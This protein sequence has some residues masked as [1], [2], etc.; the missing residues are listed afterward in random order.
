MDPGRQPDVVR[1]LP[2]GGRLLVY[3]HGLL[4]LREA[5]WILEVLEKAWRHGAPLIVE[6]HFYPD[7]ASAASGLALLAARVGA[8]VEAVYEAAMHEAWDGV[9]RLH[10]VVSEL[11]SMPRPD[12]EA[13]L[14]HEAMHAL[15]HGGLE[16]YLLPG[17]AADPRVY[18][19]AA[20]AVKDLEADAEMARRGFQ[21]LLERLAARL[22]PGAGGCP[23]TLEGLLDSL[24]HAAAQVALG[25]SPRE[26]G[27]LRPVA[28][29]MERLLE[30]WRRGGVRPWEERRRVYQAL[31]ET[32]G[33]GLG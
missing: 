10:L 3:V 6:A 2:G 19:A 9:P 32:M 14:V 1:R 5:S 29:A 22:A 25:R 33:R 30:E 16:Y 27:C 20:T 26:P 13:L 11:E 17:W 28:L 24:R 7:P 21:G 31:M 18:Y 15:L 12:A 8:L 23:S 4:S